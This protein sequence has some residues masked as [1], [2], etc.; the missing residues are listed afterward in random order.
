MNVNLQA[1]YASG[2]LV[3]VAFFLEL[4]FQATSRMLFEFF[5]EIQIAAKALPMFQENQGWFE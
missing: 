1:L 2:N 4:L 5:Y 3:C